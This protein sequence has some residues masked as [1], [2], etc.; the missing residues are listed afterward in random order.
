MK[1]DL[2]I[3]PEAEQDMQD[4]FGWYEDRV[5]GLGREFLRCVDASID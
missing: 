5:P 3:R 2:V 1:Y 4:A